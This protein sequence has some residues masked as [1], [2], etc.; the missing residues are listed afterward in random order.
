[1]GDKI[2]C[3]KGAAVGFAVGATRPDSDGWHAIKRNSMQ[4]HPASQRFAFILLIARLPDLVHSIM[5]YLPDD[6]N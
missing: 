2:A 5:P 1:M 6:F 4:H 3:T